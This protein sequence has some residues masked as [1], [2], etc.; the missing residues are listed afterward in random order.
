MKNAYFLRT[1][2]LAVLPLEH[3]LLARDLFL[4][5]EASFCAQ[6]EALEF[7]DI[8]LSADAAEPGAPL[9]RARCHG[10]S[11]CIYIADAVDSPMVVEPLSHEAT[12]Y[13]DEKLTTEDV[14][15]ASL[16][17]FP[18]EEASERLEVYMTELTLLR[19]QGEWEAS[20]E[21]RQFLPGRAGEADFLSSFFGGVELGKLELYSTFVREMG[22]RLHCCADGLP[23]YPPDDSGNCV[24]YGFLPSPSLVIVGK[25]Q[26]NAP[27]ELRHTLFFADNDPV[28]ELEITELP[29]A[30]HP[31]RLGFADKTGCTF[32]AESL[33]ALLL[34]PQLRCG[35]RFTW[36]L[37]MVAHVLTEHTSLD[38]QRQNAPTAPEEMSIVRHGFGQRLLCP[39][40]ASS[41]AIASGI[42]E[43]VEKKELGVQDMLCIRL[44]CLAGNDDVRLNVY[45]SP[46]LSGGCVPRAGDTISVIGTLFAS[47]DSL[48]QAPSWKDSAAE[49]V[50]VEADFAARSLAMAAVMGALARQGWSIGENI[51]PHAPVFAAA[52]PDG[53]RALFVVNSCVNGFGALHALS[54]EDARSCWPGDE[55]PD[56]CYVLMVSLQYRRELGRY[57]LKLK[58]H[59]G[60]PDKL[61][62]LPVVRPA[63]TPLPGEAAAMDEAALVTHLAACLR[64]Q[65][66]AGLA[67]FLPEHVRYESVGE[68]IFCEGKQW[69]LERLARR[70]SLWV[71]RGEWSRLRFVPGSVV[72]HT[73]RRISCCALMVDGQERLFTLFEGDGWHIRSVREVPAQ[74]CADFQPLAGWQEDEAEQPLPP[75][76]IVQKMPAAGM[77]LD[78]FVASMEACAEE[79]EDMAPDEDA[80]EAL[81]RE[82]MD[83]EEMDWEDIDWED[84]APDDED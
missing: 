1:Y 55:V 53:T 26:E 39:L 67:R 20:A 75:C 73:S 54:A 2:L 45:V 43:S 16:L 44:L 50:K 40:S 27:F 25:E 51:W 42:V 76:P 77:A 63:C 3:S 84:E 30:E 72:Y 28:S 5:C 56:T 14:Y 64:H 31:T 41:E 68:N 47:P 10:R 34:R 46:H 62:L 37:S 23:S 83:W 17:F 79:W 15:C 57:S 12:A 60:F 7:T 48:I 8:A 71:N 66:W 70:C 82:E 38:Q 9:L 74:F 78:A 36:T 13:I 65:D 61:G 69:M 33:E 35:Q 18:E 4:A 22:M 32:Y 24:A 19:C 80:W 29:P 11:A 6:L 58:E 59:G 49:G 21:A 81:V 52:Q